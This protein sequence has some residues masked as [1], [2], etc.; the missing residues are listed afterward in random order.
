MGLEHRLQRLEAR[1]PPP[2]E[3]CRVCGI[4]FLKDGAGP[5][6]PGW[7]LPVEPD[8]PRAGTALGCKACQAWIT[9]ARL[10]Q[11][12]ADGGYLVAGATPSTW[13]EYI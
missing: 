4:A 2:K 3:P 6:R 13:P 9:V 12:S 8:D 7:V 10:P 11:V 1:V 5:V